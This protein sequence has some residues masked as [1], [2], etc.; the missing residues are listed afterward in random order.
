MPNTAKVAVSVVQP[1]ATC[2]YRRFQPRPPTEEDGRLGGNRCGGE[3]PLRFWG[4]ELRNDRL[5]A[6]LRVDQFHVDAD[7]T[8]R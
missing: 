4:K 7:G 8:I 5:K 3:L 2:F 1:P 6:G